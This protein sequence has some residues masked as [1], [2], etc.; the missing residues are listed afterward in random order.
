[1]LGF[2]ETLPSLFEDHKMNS[3][4]IKIKTELI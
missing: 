2:W 4:G 3:S 1:M